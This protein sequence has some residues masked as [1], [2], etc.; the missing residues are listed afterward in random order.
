MRLPPER[1][2][3]PRR[4]VIVSA[5]ALSL[6][7]GIALSATR[8]AFAAD[9]AP[10]YVQAMG[11][12]ALAILTADI[13]QAERIEGM[14]T[15]FREGLDLKII[16]RFALGQHWHAA[17]P[18]QRAEYEETFGRVMVGHYARLWAQERA[19][20]FRITG[21]QVLGE[22]DTLVNTEVVR[23]NK[24][25][26]RFGWRVRRADEGFRIVD[27]MVDGISMLITQRD[28]F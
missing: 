22:R 2:R 6:A 3:L 13:P 15:L 25:A 1:A 5:L 10:A 21:A 17:T 23:E 18:E 26:L 28:D 7:G 14:A 27:L 20:S 19:K 12:R 9:T 16:A 24:P 4:H 11:E 8:A